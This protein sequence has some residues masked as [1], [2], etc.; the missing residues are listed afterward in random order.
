MG[1]LAGLG[2]A[3]AGGAQLASLFKKD[4]A[5]MSMRDFRRAEGQKEMAFGPEMSRQQRFL[6][7]MTP[8][9]ANAYNTF[10]DMTYG[11]ESQRMKDRMDVLYEGTTPWERLG[12]PKPNQVT[13][14][15]HSGK[16]Q[17]NQSV[18]QMIQ[19]GS[20]V[21]AA[22]ESAKGNIIS[23]ALGAVSNLAST[24]MTTQA[25][26]DVANINLSGVMERNEIEAFRATIQKMG[27]E[28]QLHRW[29]EMTLNER[30]NVL[31]TYVKTL[32]DHAPKGQVNTMLFKMNFI[33]PKNAKEITSKYRQGMSNIIDKDSL[34]ILKDPDIG[35]ML[36]DGTKST[37]PST[38]DLPGMIYKFLNGALNQQ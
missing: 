21:Q 31:N 16:G 4:S 23:S 38:Y 26:R 10:A 37:Q 7:G 3:L 24:G 6:E 30:G 29:N 25:S 34:P 18:G 11:K 35:E 19:A 27:V 13:A 20:Q 1:F 36:L 15:L 22:R 5:G 8:V 28:N 12:A 9:E 17:S 2:T 32:L 33:D 14:P